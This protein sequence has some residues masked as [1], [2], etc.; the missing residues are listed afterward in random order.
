MVELTALDWVWIVLYLLL[1][2]GC[3]LLFYRLGKRSEADF[4][5]A[6]RGLPWWL[7]AT[8]VYAT[9]TATDTPMWVTGVVYEHGLRGLW[10]TFFSAWCAISALVSARIF[11]RSLAYSQAEWQSVRFSGLGSEL[12][13]GWMAGWNIFLNM[14]ILGWVGM[15]M[16]KVCHFA[17]GWPTWV[18]LV[19]FST[20]CAIYVLAAGYWGVVM[21]DFQQ[22]VIAFI[23]ILI[24]SFWGILA[25]GGPEQII[26]RLSQMGESWRL[27][28]F[29]FTGLFSGPFP[30]AWFVTILIIAIIGGF[31]MGT[32]I[33]WYAEAQRIQSAKTVR[34]ASY[35][36]WAG[37]A[38]VL[39]RN[40]LWAA[41]VLAFFVL[42]PDIPERAE[43][44]LGWHRLGFELL[45]TGLLG[46]FFATIV[47]IHLSTVTTHLNL[48]A[49]YATRDLYHHYFRPKA[50]ER[51][52]VWVGRIS[53]LIL[54][55]GSFF[56]GLMMEE[57]TK[58]LIF[59]L[60]IMTA[61]VWL[62]NILQ[63]VWWRFNA[64]GYLAAWI[65]NLG[66]S[67]LVVWVLPAFKLIPALPDYVQFWILMGLGAL[68]YIPVMYFT[69]PEEMTSLVRYYVMSRPIGWW[70]PVRAEAERL[71]LMAELDVRR[72]FLIKRDWTAEEADEWTREDWLA[73]VVSPLA[74]MAL[75][76][77]VAL[78]LF[79]MWS[80]LVL[81]ILGIALA[82]IMYWVIDP[83]LRA[84]SKGYEKKQKQYL[85][86]LE[87]IVRWEVIK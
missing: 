38:L 15:A 74:Y 52:L 39:T 37:T 59:A 36:I 33:D 24:V 80:G 77:G 23:G 44:E 30:V 50:C 69:P 87:K 60:W 84:V 18:G 46:F 68:I 58:W 16:G 32:A 31:G 85:E 53:T 28:P 72:R 51:E 56:Y 7:P 11:R 47:A 49:L 66:L 54:L 45:P 29:A 20:V 1:M 67:W 82:A 70:G 43:F 8:S 14:F 71:G 55:G 35:A 21:A 4:F 2:I 12:L 34:D 64:W 63:V 75:M 57:I 79:K 6:G 62:P 65:A 3:G 40:S 25:A 9:H 83:K 76:I 10:Y 48:G 5:L 27:D 78:T 22:G 26:L 13:R 86:H 17:F 61:G 42:Y 73:I 19:V 81:F 41:A